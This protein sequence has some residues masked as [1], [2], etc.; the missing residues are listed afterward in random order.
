MPM[1][2]SGYAAAAMPAAFATIRVRDRRGTAVRRAGTDLGQ[3][4]DPVIRRAVSGQE[5][6]TLP[7]TEL[8]NNE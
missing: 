5:Q 6:T 4:F 8:N 7:F 3:W 1:T 2:A